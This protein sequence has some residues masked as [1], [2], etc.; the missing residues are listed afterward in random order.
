MNIT[1]WSD[2]ACPFC[3]IGETRLKKAIQELEEEKKI[4]KGQVKVTMKAFQL[5]P[6]AGLHASGDTLSRFAQKYNLS[7]EEAAAQINGISQMGRAEGLDFNYASTL[8]TNTMDAHRLTKLAQHTG[9][10]AQVQQVIE[11]LMQAYFAENKELADKKLLQQIGEE[12]ELS[13]N[14]VQT[15]LASDLYRDEVEEDE[16]EAYSYGI[17]AVPFFLVAGR[18]GIN[19]AQEIAG[20]K[21]VILQAVREDEVERQKAQA[22]AA[23]TAAPSG[24]VCGPQGCSIAAHHAAENA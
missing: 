11:K 23:V 20:M 12:A 10:A 4:A 1:Y 21:E 3:Y 16:R 7:M 2:Y 22:A 19:G 6:A 8:F 14:T 24:M 5:D 13:A 18:Y 15:M 17:H 9:T